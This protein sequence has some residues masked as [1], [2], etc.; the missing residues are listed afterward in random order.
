LV[1]Q[2]YFPPPTGVMGCQTPPSRV[3]TPVGV[4]PP[5]TVTVKTNVVF[6]VPLPGSTL[7]VN[8]VVPHENA[9]VGATN[10][11]STARSQPTR[12][13]PRRVGDVARMSAVDSC[14]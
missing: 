7:P 4:G 10:Q 12:R 13:S 5:V 6:V 11:G 9:A 1:D 8:T 14:A 3:K 2:V